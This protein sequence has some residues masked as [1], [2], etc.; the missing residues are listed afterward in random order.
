MKTQKILRISLIVVPIALCAYAGFGNGQKALGWIEFTKKNYEAAAAHFQEAGDQSGL[1][2]VALA[3]RRLET[4]T[5]QLTRQRDIEMEKVERQLGGKVRQEQDRQKWLA[6]LLPPIPPLVV[7][8]FV[9]FRRR[10][11]EREGVAKTRL[12]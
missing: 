3:Q 5:E 6:V 4:K 10:A 2:M 7:A 1:G 9:Y 12:R 11:Q 8:F